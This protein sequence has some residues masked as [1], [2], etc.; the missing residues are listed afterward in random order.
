MSITYEPAVWRPSPNFAAGRDG[1]EV[2]AIVDHITAGAL[3]PSLNWLTNPAAKVSSHYVVARNGAVYQL[4]R[5]EDTAWAQGIDFSRGYAA[6]GSDLAIPWIR[7][8]WA[9]ETNPNLVAISIEHEQTGNEGLT[10]VQYAATLALHRHLCQRWN[11]PADGEHVVGHS[12]IDA[13]NRPNDPGKAFP[14][15]RLFADIAAPAV[16]LQALKEHVSAIDALS[17]RMASDAGEIANRA[18]AIW[19]AY[20]LGTL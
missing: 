20:G 19:E 9:A 12:R 11:I 15:A 13:V 17:K 2:I 7:D 1:H 16:D 5:E 18:R 14:F 6:Y 10:E 3:G 8:A 4:V